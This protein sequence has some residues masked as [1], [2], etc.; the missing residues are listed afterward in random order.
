MS[1]KV[2]GLAGLLSALNPLKESKT[3]IVVAQAEHGLPVEYGTSRQ[4]AQPFARPGTAKALGKF[5]ETETNAVTLQDAVDG[6]A[7]DIAK[8][9]KKLVPVDTGELKNSIEVIHG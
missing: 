8:E 9:W 5:H 6:L 3:V 4:P 2:A 7:E 1:M